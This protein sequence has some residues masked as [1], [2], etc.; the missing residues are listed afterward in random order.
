[1]IFRIQFQILAIAITVSLSTALSSTGKAQTPH[2]PVVARVEMRLSD[3]E[4]LVDVIEKGDLLTVIEERDDVYV[5]KTH[6]GA[7]GAV[8]KV[9]AVKIPEAV[10]IYT[11]LILRQPSAGRFYTLRASSYWALNETEKALGDFDRAIELGY[12]KPHAYISR[13][14]FHAPQGDHEQAIADYNKAIEIDP[15]DIAPLINRAA[16]HMV[17]GEYTEAAKDYT[18]ALAKDTS[19]NA[20]LHQRA[21][22]YK[23]AGDF[24][25]A[26][27]DFSTLIKRDSKDVV[28]IMGR[29]Y[30]RFQQENHAAAIKDFAAAIKINPKDAVAYNNLGYNR[31]KIGEYAQALK[32]YNKAI[33]LNEKYSLAHQN[34]AWLLATVTNKDLRN[35]KAAVKSAKLACELTNFQSVSDIAALAAALAANGQFKE[36]VGWQEKVVA[37]VNEHYKVFATKTLERYKDERPFAQDPDKAN[38]AERAAA[39]AKGKK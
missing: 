24:A 6:D 25:K 19:R 37:M 7:K 14:L 26:S 17:R 31:F 15:K 29:G 5:I 2:E 33:E 36:A 10:E 1:M 3:G 35:P 21:I 27:D 18:D 11:E 38:Q 28:A 12:E 16:V 8:D 23:A 22:A 13:G 30:I 39:E 9:N 34:R 32:D 20:L 4:K